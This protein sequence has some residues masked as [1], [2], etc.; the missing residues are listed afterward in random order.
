M[1]QISQ[2]M[3]HELN[4]NYNNRNIFSK[5]NL[6]LKIF[7][8]LKMESGNKVTACIGITIPWN[9]KI[10]NTK[11]KKITNW[12]KIIVEKL[13]KSKKKNHCHYRKLTHTQM[14]S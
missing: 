14:N 3:D 8:S 11:K 7:D 5:K 6:N 10:Q 1:N 12:K 13:R 2:S 4:P 9:A